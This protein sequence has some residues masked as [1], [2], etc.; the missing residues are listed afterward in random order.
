MKFKVFVSA[1]LTAMFA[2][3]IYTSYTLTKEAQKQ[4]LMQETGYECIL[5]ALMLKESYWPED[6]E[7]DR[8]QLLSV[9]CYGD[10]DTFT[11]LIHSEP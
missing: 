11:A 10:R 1:I 7:Y 3:L 2:T 8:Q 6:F 5:S 9:R 4:T